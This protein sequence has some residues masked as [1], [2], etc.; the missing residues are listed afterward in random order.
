MS[1]IGSQADGT[2][3]TAPKARLWVVVA[4]LIV[5]IGISLSVVGA[6]GTADGQRERAHQAFLASSAQ[7]SSTLRLAIQH[8]QDLAVSAGAFIADDPGATESQFRQWAGAV[9]AFE[10]YP[11]MLGIANIA[12]VPASELSAFAS[13]AVADPAGPL[14]PNGAFD[15]TPQG[16]RPYY[17]LLTVSASRTGQSAT[18]AGIDY[19][20]TALGPSLLGTRDSG[21]GT[22]IPFDEYGP[23]GLAIGTPVYRGGIDPGTVAARQAAFVGWTGI[24]I[25]PGVVLDTSLKGHPGMAVAFTY[26]SSSAKATFT[27]GRATADPQSSSTDLGNGWSVRTYG[28]SGSRGIFSNSDAIWLLTA[29]MMLSVLIGSLVILLATS[30]SRAL[31]LVRRRTE[32]LRHM[33]LYD[34]LTGLPNRLL[35]HDRIEQLLARGRRDQ[36]PIAVLFLDLDNFK[37]INDTLGHAAGDRLLAQVSARLVAVLREEDTVGRLGGDEFILLVEG[38]SLQDGTM[39]VAER[40]LDSLK[41]PFT[42]S[43]DQEP[44]YIT[45]SIGIAEGARSTPDE[46]LQDADIALYRA[47]ETGRKRAVVFSPSMHA[48][49]DY[50]R[51]LELDLQNGLETGQ[52]FL[53]YQPIV[54][55]ATGDVTGVEALLRWRH[56]QRGVVQPDRFIP[57]LESTG[58]IVPVGRWVL[59]TACVQGRYWQSHGHDL[60][61]SVN[62]SAEQLDQKGIVDDVYEALSSSGF[63]SSL[64]V[65][66][67]TERSLM[68]DAAATARRLAQLK[69]LGVRVA[70]DDFGT[71]YSSLSC[72]TQFPIDILKIDKSFVNG[73]TTSSESAALIDT[74]VQLARTLGL[75]TIAEGI[76]TTGQWS[77]LTAM[78]VDAGQGFA[79]SRPLEAGAVLELASN[80]DAQRVSVAR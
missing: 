29:G 69:S 11:E 56:P 14:G 47:K 13:R 7:I 27:A 73:V 32:E 79:F 63:D 15:V 22:Y 38:M 44:I 31:L 60:S 55:L 18:P 50:D 58:L 65:L 39:S 25:D 24:Q 67:L 1:P 61:M 20:D 26:R 45:A 12:M 40:V 78:G 36:T 64:L 9:E 30:R 35:I 57:V 66:E 48:S 19:C 34:S 51:S 8:E 37:V 6:K 21:K 10:R 70:V 49:A 75:E 52:F 16:S 53:L 17:C 5:T 59:Q 41:A 74:Q 23:P 80:P 3:M 68:P 77:Q 2:P 71:G 28:A 72:L 76:E 43:Q 62:L 4:L 54:S 42:I 46:L 33:A